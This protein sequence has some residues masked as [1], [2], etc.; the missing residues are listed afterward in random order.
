MLDATGVQQW[1]ADPLSQQ[2]AQISRGHH[3]DIQPLGVL[4]DMGERKSDDNRRNGTL[5]RADLVARVEGVIGIRRRGGDDRA[6]ATCGVWK[7]VVKI[8]NS[9]ELRHWEKLPR[10]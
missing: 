7:S 9:G 4:S 8:S 5:V 10:T 3:A 6:V 1:L 2:C